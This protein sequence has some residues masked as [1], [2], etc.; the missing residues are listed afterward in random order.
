MLPYYGHIPRVK[1]IHDRA[2][3][4][5]KKFTRVL[6]DHLKKNGG[7]FIVG[8]NITIADIA[9]ATTLASPL[10]YVWDEKYRKSIQN[11]TKW[12]QAITS[13]ETWKKVIDP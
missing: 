11:L 8:Q 13:E 9:V 1:S 2:F 10:Q 7:K 6:D 4:D 5:V 12:F 3:E